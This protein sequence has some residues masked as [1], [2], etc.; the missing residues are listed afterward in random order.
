M[1]INDVIGPKYITLYDSEAIGSCVKSWSD[2]VTKQNW[3]TKNIST[4]L[5]LR[6]L[7]L[8][9][10]KIP[11]TIVKAQMPSNPNQKSRM[12]DNKKF[13]WQTN[14]LTMGSYDA[15]QT[16]NTVLLLHEFNMLNDPT[17]RSRLL[18]YSRY[19]HD[20]FCIFIQRHPDKIQHKFI[21]N[22]SYLWI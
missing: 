9:K 10:T 11:I 4:R 7:K 18:N 19:I 14:G 2:L 8:S 15:Q 1:N 12:R 13:Y 21:S 6:A 20:G 5:R 17:I 3:Y 22:Y 16:S